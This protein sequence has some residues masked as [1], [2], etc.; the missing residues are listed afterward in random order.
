[1]NASAT[2]QSEVPFRRRRDFV[3]APGAIGQVARTQDG[4]VRPDCLPE[5][6]VAAKNTNFVANPFFYG[7]GYFVDRK[8]K[9]VRHWWI[10][11]TL[12]HH[13][14]CVDS[15]FLIR[16]A[17]ARL[18]TNMHMYGCAHKTQN[19]HG[20]HFRAAVESRFVSAPFSRRSSTE[21]QA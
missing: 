20:A 8:A 9:S 5:H 19:S 16:D 2:I 14:H 10:R 15:P 1:M 7:F 21:E 12:K 11:N 6:L 4:N 3:A 18:A 17:F 13:T